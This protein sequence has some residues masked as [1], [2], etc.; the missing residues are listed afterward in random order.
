MA[1]H[2]MALSALLLFA[3]PADFPRG[4]I[5]SELGGK[6]WTIR[7]ADDGKFTPASD[8]NPHQRG[9]SC[10]RSLQIIPCFERASLDF[11]GAG[12]D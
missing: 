8:G 3:G 9:Q 1:L 12:P 11:H 2:P 5:A 10:C 7:F 6:E 4:T